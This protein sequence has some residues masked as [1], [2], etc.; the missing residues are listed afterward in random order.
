MT[1]FRLHVAGLLFVPESPRWLLAS[2]QKNEAQL[3]AARLWGPDGPQM[4]GDGEA[5]SWPALPVSLHSVRCWW[6]S[7]PFLR[8]QQL[9]EPAD[10]RTVLDRQAEPASAGS[11]DMGG[12][13]RHR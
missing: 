11:G 12:W 1:S 10:D 3:A 4:L 13:E 6:A 8:Q 2:G 9:Y 5:P 7:R